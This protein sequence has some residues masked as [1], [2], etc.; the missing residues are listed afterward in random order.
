[1]EPAGFVGAAPDTPA[2]RAMYDEDLAGLGYVMNCVRLWAHL[3]EANSGLFD[4]AG[5]S[6]K[7][8]GLSVRER[9]ILITA[10]A[11][12]MHDSSCSLAWG[13]KLAGLSGPSRRRGAGRHD[14]GLSTSEGA[15]AR[16]AREVTA[17]P[18]RTREEDVEAL[19][20][21]GYDD[22]QI[23]AITV[24]VAMRQAFAVVN[25]ALGLKPDR[26]LGA[27]APAEVREVVT[28]GRPVEE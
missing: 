1:M 19:R 16:W 28:Y 23:V 26:E 21:A 25:D 7:A 13:E 17:D 24:F 12:T 15:L 2:A 4:V 9:G 5:R 14:T 18:T 6:A 3:P 8:A 10:M 27:N 22:T 20:L 11:A